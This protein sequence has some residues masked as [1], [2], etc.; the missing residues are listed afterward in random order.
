M[1]KLLLILII[2]FCGHILTAQNTDWSSPQGG[3][4]FNAQP[5]HVC[6]SKENRDLIKENI[7]TNIEGLG[8]TINKSTSTTPNFEWP[9][10]VSDQLDFFDYNG[11]TN[12]LDHDNTPNIL[13][14]NCED[15][16]YNGHKGTDFVLWPFP[17]YLYENEFVEVVAAQAGVIIEKFD[18]QFDSNCTW[19]GNNSTWNAVYLM[20]DDG[21]IT[22]YGHLKENILTSKSIGET[23]EQ[24]EFLG[25][26]ASSGFSDIPHLH[27]EVYDDEGVLVDPFSGSCSTSESLWSNQRTYRKPTVNALLTHSNAPELG[28]PVPNEIP[29]FS[30][31]FNPGEV[32]YLAAY[33]QDQMANEAYNYSIISPD[34]LV[35]SNWSH[36]STETF[37]LSYWYWTWTPNDNA[38]LGIWTFQI[39]RNGLIREH[40]FNYGDVQTSIDNEIDND[41]KIYP[42]PV[43]NNISIS[44][45]LLNVD[46]ITIFNNLGKKLFQTKDI[47]PEINVASFPNGIYFVRLK[48]TKNI[49]SI[50]KIIIQN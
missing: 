49:E 12:F 6:L 25:Y 2:P 24:G 20:H 9:L 7:Q 48:S 38:P 35:V 34:G 13:D 31:Q 1:K 50:N 41:I 11:I 4:E 17:W 33:F 3:G 21:Y 42:N 40:Q 46:E 36:S 15:R 28:C 10:A 32:I 18:G 14:Y 19:V 5:E 44:G 47:S 45:D 23:V 16:S 26:V 27:F 37:N 22:W 30:N 43:T 8:I 39:E 29:H